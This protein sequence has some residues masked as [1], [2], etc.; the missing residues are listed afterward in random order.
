MH[1]STSEHPRCGRQNQQILSALEQK[2]SRC[3][4]FTP[5]TSLC[6]DHY[7]PCP[8]NLNF[9]QLP[10]AVSSAQGASGGL[11]SKIVS[12]YFRSTIP[13]PFARVLPSLRALPG[14]SPTPPSRRPRTCPFR[15]IAHVP[16]SRSQIAHV[17]GCSRLGRDGSLR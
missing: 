7:R 6:T 13:S 10:L 3:Y 16:P 5:R 12:D 8:P 15:Q 17:A 9:I 11:C 2:L 1:L 14:A 4:A